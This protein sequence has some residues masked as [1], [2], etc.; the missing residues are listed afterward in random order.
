VPGAEILTHSDLLSRSRGSFLDRR[1]KKVSGEH[2]QL[3]LPTGEHTFSS[4]WRLLQETSA[5]NPFEWPRW[6]L[7]SPS[8]LFRRVAQSLCAVA[9]FPELR[10]FHDRRGPVTYT[11]APFRALRTSLATA[12]YEVK[13]LTPEY[14][15]LPV[16][17]SG[18]LPKKSKSRP[19]FPPDLSRQTRR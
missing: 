17:S 9:A 2:G 7:T 8:L 4:P 18:L 10:F 14:G 3:R 12:C 16:T 19:K 13:T 1:P 5:K 6:A 15:K 11:S